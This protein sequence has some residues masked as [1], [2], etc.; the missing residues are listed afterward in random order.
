MDGQ[1]ASRTFC[2]ITLI[3][4]PSY[5]PGAL[6]LA[7]TLHTQKSLYPL[8][9]QYTSSLGSDAI[10]TLQQEAAVAQ[11][12]ILEEVSLLIPRRDQENVGSVADRFKD[13]FT[14]LRAFQAY[15][16]NFTKCIFL[17]AD[18]AVFNNPD[19]AF[20][21][22]LPSSDWLGANHACVCNLDKDPWAPDEWNADNC[23][24]TPLKSSDLVAPKI[25]SSDRPTYKI[26]NSGMFLFHPSEQLWLSMLDYFNSSD[27]LKGYQFPDQDF[28]ADFFVGRW[29]PMSWKYNAIK[30]MRYWHPNIWSDE[31]VVVL[32]YIVDKPWSKRVNDD[33]TAGYLGRDGV[34][35]SWWWALYEEWRQARSC[36]G[37]TPDRENGGIQ[38]K[39]EELV[40]MA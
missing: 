3:T 34:T 5:L 21:T 32:H 18:M 1:R 12:I 33:G 29:Q 20:D 4:K 26:L 38:A 22:D 16:H 24:Y 27:K 30:T 14:K 36:G 35:H 23:A 40:G 31:K 25:R 39:V 10:E 17:D 6:I 7:R 8:L 13:T 19:D 11:N 2:W 9:I 15:E 28:L 37:L